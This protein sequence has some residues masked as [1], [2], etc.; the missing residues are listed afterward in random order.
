V[1]YIAS[2]TLPKLIVHGHYHRRY[3]QHVEADGW[4]SD[5]EGFGCDGDWL[6]AM[7]VL[8]TRTLRVESV[9]AYPVPTDA[10]G[11]NARGE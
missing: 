11:S 7:G 9:D 1:S 8:D 3:S 10:S 4:F 6:G 2:K 5:V